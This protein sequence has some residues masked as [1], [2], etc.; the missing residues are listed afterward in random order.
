MK[1][2]SGRQ[3]NA[4][5][6]L[7]PKRAPDPGLPEV[8]AAA[9]EGDGVDPRDEAKRKLQE[10]RTRSAGRERGAHRKERFA[11]QVE[12]TIDG[13]LQLAAEP[14]LNALTVREV[15]QQGGALLV[16]AEP[17]DPASPLDLSAAR[18]ALKKA[19]T[20]LTREVAQEITRKQIPILSF[21][22]LPA[23]AERMET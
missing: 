12:E 7:Q 10:R 17:R 19:A 14:L 18:Q 20:M 8:V 23:G 2:S 22:V 11:A 1:K 15:V 13:A 16:V 21:V 6:D 4:R 3:T 9:R 5:P